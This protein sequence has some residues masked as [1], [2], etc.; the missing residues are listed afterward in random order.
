VE[1][2]DSPGPDFEPSEIG[3][4]TY[5]LSGVYGSADVESV[6]ATLRRAHDLGI[7]LFDTAPGYGNAEEVMSG[8]IRDFRR[9]ILLSTKV[10]GDTAGKTCTYENILA[11]CEKSLKDLNVD[12]IDLYSIHFDD[13][14]SPV[15][16]VVGAFEELKKAGKIRFYGLGHVFLRRARRYLEAGHFSTVMGELSAVS[17]G[18]YN[19]MLPLLRANGAGYLGFSVTGRGVLTGKVTGRASLERGDIRHIDALFAGERLKSALRICEKMAETAKEI[20]ATPAQVAIRWVLN[21]E[22]VKCAICGPSS[23]EHLEENFGAAE[24]RGDTDA[25]RALEEFIRQESESVTC[26]L[27]EEVEN[28]LRSPSP[29]AD[30]ISRLVYAAENMG[31]LGMVPDEDLIPVFKQLLGCLRGNTCD[32]VTVN[33]VKEALADLLPD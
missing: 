30:A 4:G 33:R 18:Y 23:V 25:F 29:G 22:A 26:T 31:E 1:Q 27:R 24:L 8:V 17:T 3:V 28:I 19:K 7:T 11:S 2:E 32:D 12:H 13:G 9:D 15:E 10:A 20:K 16:D 6:R 21:R 5:C 14:S